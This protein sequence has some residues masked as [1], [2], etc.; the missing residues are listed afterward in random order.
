LMVDVL[1]TL[2]LRRHLPSVSSFPC[3]TLFRSIETLNRRGY[4][5]IAPVSGMTPGIPP[6]RS[7]TGRITVA[8]LPFNEL[9]AVPERQDF[10]DGRSE[11]HASELQSPANN[12]C[13]LLLEKKQLQND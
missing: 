12:A 9:S 6:E 8:V 7:L 4:R 11:E 13:H 2:M 1:L 3:P 10:S 5:F